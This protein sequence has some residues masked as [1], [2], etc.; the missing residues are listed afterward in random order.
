MGQHY[1]P[2]LTSIPAFSY[3]PGTPAHSNLLISIAHIGC[4][5]VLNH[6]QP[7]LFSKLQADEQHEHKLQFLRAFRTPNLHR[8]EKLL[9]KQ[10]MLFLRGIVRFYSA[11]NAVDKKDLLTKMA[12][13]GDKAL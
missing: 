8:A 3:R 13:V 12:A 2:G 5:W 1:I 6:F 11:A 10:S 4:S 9:W 7:I